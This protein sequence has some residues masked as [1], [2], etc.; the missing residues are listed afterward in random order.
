MKKTSLHISLALIA[1]ASLAGC[2]TTNDASNGN[3]EK[4]INEKLENHCIPLRTGYS[5]PVVDILFSTESQ[6]HNRF[7]KLN[8]LV[9]AGL[10]SAEKEDIIKY[11]EKA[12]RHT[13]KLTKEGE[14][15]IMEKTSGIFCIGKYK[16]QKIINFTVPS[17]KLGRM[18]S[19]VNY[20]YSPSEVPAWA[21]SEDIKKAFPLIVSNLKETQEGSITLFLYNDGWSANP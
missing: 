1:A 2:D 19:R 10:L 14:R 4:A 18:L 5:F 11:R 7:D 6:Y 12:K 8:A 13:Y 15:Y 9:K 17:D 21:K 16:V 20:T 3:F